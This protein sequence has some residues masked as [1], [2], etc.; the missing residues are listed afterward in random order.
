MFLGSYNPP[1]RET[2]IKLYSITILRTVLHGKII[3]GVDKVYLPL[4]MYEENNA[5]KLLLSLRHR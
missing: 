3:Y 2:G 4:Y 5:K 1:L